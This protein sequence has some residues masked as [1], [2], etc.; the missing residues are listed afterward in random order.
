MGSSDVS[1]EQDQQRVTIRGQ[2][3]R[4]RFVSE[5]GAFAVC[6]L[7]CDAYPLPVTMVGNILGAQPGESLEVSGRFVIDARFGRQLKIE[8]LRAT[9]PASRQGIERYLGG[10]L[11]DGIGP[12]LAGRIVERFG[13]RTL[14]VL[15]VEPEQLLEVEGIGSARLER[16]ASAWG[17]QKS[18]RDVMI[19]LQMHSISTVFAEKIYK[20]YGERAAEIVREDPYR[21][22]E[23]VRGIGFRK[24][25]AIALSGGL[26]LDALQRLSAGVLFALREA[27]LEG[28]MYLPMDLL[29]AKASALLG[30]SS[31]E[32]LG[33]AVEALRCEEKLVLE[34]SLE[35]GE[36]TAV[37]RRAS[38]RVEAGLARH[39]LRLIEEG[40]AAP[41]LLE[42]LQSGE[43]ALRSAER[44]MSVTL[45]PLQRE[46]V[47]EAWRE[48][49]VVITGG[50]G[51]GKTTIVRA[52]VAV[53]HQ[54]GARLAL[55]APTGRAAKR[56]QEA[57]GEPAKTL[58][59]LLE[60]G[61]QSGFQIDEQEPLELDAL[62]IDEASMVDTA[63]MLAAAR[64]LPSGARLI[65]VGD[66]DQLP[67]VG[68]GNVLRDVIASGRA[69]V[70]RL[71]QIFRQDERSHI[72]LN[73]HRINRGEMPLVP[74][75]QGDEL[76]DFYAIEA[77]SPA[78]AQQRVVQL[79][80][81]RIPHAFGLNPMSEVQV[82]SP[83]HRGE[84]GCARLNELLQETLNGSEQAL[85]GELVRASRRF[86]PGDKVMQRRNNYE[87]DVYNGD[88]GLI[89]R[90][91]HE[92]KEIVVCYEEGRQATYGF[93]DLEEIALAYAITAHKSQGSEYRAVVLALTTQH[94][95]MLQR[96]LIYTAITRAKELVIVVG[97]HRAM[98]IAVSRDGSR[99]R[100]TR[101]CER[102]RG[103][104]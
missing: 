32:G 10:G 5:D 37:W 77:S 94:Y 67:S 23:D 54:R 61:F 31:E 71:T 18:V 60:Y 70:V 91:D 17:A 12:V 100:F 69:G 76:V 80:G 56:L 33:D 96:N 41:G 103:E 42:R 46:A 24:A 55:A 62:I 7:N 85:A 8:H 3:S 36:A 82:I 2:L 87:Q 15:D 93:E 34:P 79:I 51:T 63:L 78:E 4:V 81:E 92:A 53:G 59:R 90:I 20:L 57:T 72:V 89:E 35:Q 99:R 102:L 45:A 39:L 86:R 30:L 74:A 19:F 88:V 27:R 38:W 6:D 44:E 9:L 58:H 13:Q 22:A 14:D 64:A 95:V 97:G 16:I 50:P 104:L 49:V 26:E 40:G 101:L 84:V 75:R 73:A 28:H 83:M 47:R 52:L 25:D 11:I 68:P 43:G 66:V 48:R 65:L 98:A 1:E 29:L 21:L